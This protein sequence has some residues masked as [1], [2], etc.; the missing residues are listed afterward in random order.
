MIE[1]LGVAGTISGYRTLVFGDAVTVERGGAEVARCR[2]EGLGR[3]VAAAGDLRLGLGRFPD[4]A[5]VLSLYDKAGDSFGY[6][7]NLTSPGC[8]EGG[9]A[10]FRAAA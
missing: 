3:F 2:V 7:F 5:E 4:G 6:A 10:P 1:Q 9:Y 8:S